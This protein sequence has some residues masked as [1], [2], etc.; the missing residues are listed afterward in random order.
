MKEEEKLW[1]SRVAELY[2][3]HLHNNEIDFFLPTELIPL[4]REVELHILCIKVKRSLIISMIKF[5]RGSK[6]NK[7]KTGPRIK[8]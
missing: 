5:L 4:N 3:C 2:L 6:Y 1:G 7:Y 8:P